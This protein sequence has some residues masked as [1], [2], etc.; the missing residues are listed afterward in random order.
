MA[1]M[2]PLQYGSRSPDGQYWWDGSAWQPVPPA[3]QMPPAYPAAYPP[4]M[5]AARGLP[6][7][8]RSIATSILLAIVTIGI[9]T[10]FW[11]YKT[12]NEIKRYSG[13]GVGGVVGLVIY[14]VVAPVTYFVVPSEVR[15]LYEANG[16]QSPVQGT[17]GFWILL[18]LIGAI[19][20]FVKV[21]GALNTFWASVG[22]PGPGTVAPA[23]PMM[24]PP[25]ALPPP[26]PPPSA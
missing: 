12:H 4:A 7:Q 25:G 20:W 10:F 8:Q 2:P 6:G 5:T 17:T 23:A 13:I 1:Q 11:V 24:P 15:Q 9:Y 3:A 14:I 26:P 19:V 22:V 16:R 21:Q 18:P